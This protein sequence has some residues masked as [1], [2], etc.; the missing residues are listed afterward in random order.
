MKRLKE[1]KLEEP[2]VKT[3]TG[4]AVKEFTLSPLKYPGHN[5]TIQRHHIKRHVKLV[6]KTSGMVSTFE[7]SY[8]L[9]R[10]GTQSQN[11]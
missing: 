10:Q 1:D 3:L 11:I 5:Q 4:D 8:E 9:V 6:I 2:L 7:R